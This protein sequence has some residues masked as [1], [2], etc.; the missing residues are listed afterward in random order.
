MKKYVITTL[1]DKITAITFEEDKPSLINVYENAGID[2]GADTDKDAVLLGNVYIGRVQN[3]VKNINSAFIEIAK[4]VVFYY[5]L[6]DNTQHHFLNRKNTDK[7]CQG[8]LM[9]VQVSREAVKTKA[10]S[11]TSDISITGNYVVMSL[12]GKGEVAVSAKIKDN[13]FRKAIHAKLKPLVESAEG[14]ISL[15]VRTAAFD[16][17][18]S[19]IFA[20]AEYMTGIE[21]NIHIKADCRPAFTCLYK[22]EEQYICDIRE[23]KLTDADRIISDNEEI[24]SNIAEHIPSAKNIISLY[25]DKLLPLY[26]CYGFEKII[27]DALSPR[28]WLKSGAYL[29]I[30]PT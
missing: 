10:P 18:E 15:I 27:S 5:S 26:K 9:L 20:E 17:S 21:E 16:A 6:T 25:D 28:V 24:L 22:K 4:D 13:A 7:V 19:E 3:V 14:R 2:A 23:S 8:D 30:E 12:D 11:L 29:I 1:K